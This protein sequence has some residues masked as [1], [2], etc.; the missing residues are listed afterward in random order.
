MIYQ[1]YIYDRQLKKYYNRSHKIEGWYEDPREAIKDLARAS[2][3]EYNQL[4]LSELTDSSCNII[5]IAERGKVL[6]INRS[7]V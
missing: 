2:T 6:S 7:E 4:V 5:A 3:I 1:I